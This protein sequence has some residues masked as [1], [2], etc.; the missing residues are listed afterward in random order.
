M[1]SHI[2]DCQNTITHATVLILQAQYQPNILALLAG[3]FTPAG[4]LTSLSAVFG[5]VRHVRSVLN[6]FFGLSSRHKRTIGCVT[7]IAVSTSDIASL[8]RGREPTC[9]AGHSI[10]PQAPRVPHRPLYKLLASHNQL[11]V[12]ESTKTHYGTSM[13]KQRTVSFVRM[14]GRRSC[15]FRFKSNYD[16]KPLLLTCHEGTLGPHVDF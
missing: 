10:T 11:L 13:R 5:Y 9:P 6:T 16:S 4:V 2:P 8:F 15:M 3:P 12:S 1:Q 7:L 14:S